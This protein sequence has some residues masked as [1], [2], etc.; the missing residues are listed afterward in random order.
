MSGPIITC[1]TWVMYKRIIIT[2]NQIATFL[3]LKYRE[4]TCKKLRMGE[5]ENEWG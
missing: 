2:E 1:I 4:E 3:Y 5:I